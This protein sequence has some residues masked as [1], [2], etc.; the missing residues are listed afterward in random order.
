[1][2]LVAF[3]AGVLV[4]ALPGAA[5]AERAA[6]ATSTKSPPR[7][8]LALEGK[9]NH[10]VVLRLDG[11]TLRPLRGRR[12]ALDGHAG[13]WAFSP[14]RR[15]IAFGVGEALGLNLVDVRRMRR[16]GRVILANGEV[17]L[18][19][20]PT[21]NRIVG[22]ENVTGL[23]VVDPQ[24]RRL[25]RSQRLDAWVQ[26]FDRVGTSLV[27]LLAPER[28]I[29]A[30]R[31]AV[32]NP[33]GAMRSVTLDRIRA[34]SNVPE[35][36]PPDFRG[37][38]RHAALAVDAAGNRAFVV[39]AAGDP[40]AEVNLAGLAVAYR[41]P[42]ARRSFL[43]RL[44]DWLEPAA[45]AKLPMAG[46]SRWAVWLGEGLLGVSG[47][48]TTVVGE[49]A[50]TTPAGLS[51]VDTREW[52]VRQVD[53]RASGFVYVDGMLLAEGERMGLAGYTREGTRRY[54]LF[55]GRD[56]SIWTVL[57]SRVFA[58]PHNGQI[59]VIEAVTGRVVGKR[60]TMRRLLYGQFQ[61][62]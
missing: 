10:S 21:R 14:D 48:E 34:G 59:H 11:R 32:V 41:T 49:Q 37:E 25:I 15:R 2:R 5:V 62:W 43:A 23:F 6:L 51:V 55:A 1:M 27:L 57:A 46:S 44:H 39:G 56:V 40:V 3:V 29:G 18:L 42:T 45:S 30:A 19:T 31:L 22:V 24:R 54:E 53:S 16:A 60:S 26:G 33:D 17:R 36:P 50:T 7:T 8:V 9:R 58:Q 4:L 28:R 12:V 47:S 61:R 38:S 20:W 13:A 35:E 52:S